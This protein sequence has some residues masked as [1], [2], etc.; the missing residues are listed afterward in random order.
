M[1]LFGQYI[2]FTSNPEAM[3][4]FEFHKHELQKKGRKIESTPI[5]LIEHLARTDP[6]QFKGLNPYSFGYMIRG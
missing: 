1:T 6:T 4:F 2:L 3:D 5:A